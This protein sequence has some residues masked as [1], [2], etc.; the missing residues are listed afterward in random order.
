V[1]LSRHDLLRLLEPL[2]SAD[3]LGLV[4]SPAERL[5]QELIEAEAAARIGAEWNGR[6]PDGPTTAAGIGTRP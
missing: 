5:P 6:T 1:A 2:R 4:R 3:G